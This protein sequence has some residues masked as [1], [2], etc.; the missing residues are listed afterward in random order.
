[1]TINNRPEILQS[2]EISPA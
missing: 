1:L 2:S